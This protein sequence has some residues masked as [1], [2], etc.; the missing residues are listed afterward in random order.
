MKV[1]SCLLMSCFLLQAKAN[2]SVNDTIRIKPTDVN[3][4]VLKNGTH[5]WLVYFKKGKEGSR[6]GYNIWSRTITPGSFEGRKAIIVSQ[7]WEN[8]DTI[9]HTAYSVCDAAN[10][11]PLYHRFWYKG[12]PE[13]EYNFVK[14]EAKVNGKPIDNTGSDSMTIK[15]YRSFESAM[16]QYDLNWHL[17]LEVFPLLPYRPNTTYAINFYEPGYTD[18]Q[19][20]Y[21][22]LTGSAYLTGFDGQQVDCWVL[23]HEDN[24]RM[25][26]HEKFFISKKTKEVLKLEQEFAGN[27]RYKI[28]LP[29]TD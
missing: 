19:L 17:D 6:N 10:F 13:S 22:T 7:E 26:N 15:R 1:F 9:V 29:F 14:H 8:N 21:Y 23:E 2:V 5:R 4:A 24:D 28:K 18:P 25:K 3:T 12:R 20:V 16:N 11:A 27:F